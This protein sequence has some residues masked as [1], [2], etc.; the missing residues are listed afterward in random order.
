MQAAAPKTFKLAPPKFAKELAE[1]GANEPEP[2]FLRQLIAG[3]RALECRRD[4]ELELA[5]AE[6][7]SSAIQVSMVAFLFSFLMSAVVLIFHL[8][9]WVVLAVSSSGMVSAILACLSLRT[10]AK[11]RGDNL[12]FESKLADMESRS[13]I[14]EGEAKIKVLP[15][16][17][18]EAAPSLE[19]VG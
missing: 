1:N 6:G 11:K 14:A 9:A 7:L 8:P 16:P 17:V 3:D 15:V 18:D 5:A 19:K 2:A 12:L 10:S 13:L 4:G